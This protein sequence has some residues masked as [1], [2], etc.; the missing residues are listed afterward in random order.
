MPKDIRNKPAPQL[1]LFSSP[2]GVRVSH[3]CRCFDLRHELQCAVSHTN[4]TNDRAGN[5]SGI[6]VV[7]YDRAN[8]DVDY[9]SSGT[10]SVLFGDGWR[11][12]ASP[13]KRE[14]KASVSWEVWRDLRK[15]FEPGD[16][17]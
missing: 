17:W 4:Y 7:Q 15:Q 11:T 13:K 12:Y 9:I 2:A 10:C 8:K 1:H 3:I 5:N 14:E 16:S 6:V